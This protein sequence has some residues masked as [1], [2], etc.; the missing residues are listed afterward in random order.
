M[1]SGKGGPLE[2]EPEGMAGVKKWRIELSWGFPGGAVVKNPPANAGDAGSVPKSGTS[3]GEGNGNPLQYSWKF[4]G[5]RSLAGYSPWGCKELDTTEHTHTHSTE[6]TPFSLR[7]KRSVLT[8]LRV[9]EQSGREGLL[10]HQRSC[11]QTDPQTASTCCLWWLL[12]QT[13]AEPHLGS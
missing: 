8:A 13:R 6:L 7:A 11:Y 10:G 9:K 3:P 5:H 12:L 1:A 4:Q 2:K